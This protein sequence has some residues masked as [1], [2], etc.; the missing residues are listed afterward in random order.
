MGV[1][2]M[3]PLIISIM[4]LATI[5][6]AQEKRIEHSDLPAAVERTVS[7]Q[8]QGATIRVSPSATFVP[9]CSD[10]LSVQTT[11]P[12]APCTWRL[13]DRQSHIRRPAGSVHRQFG[14]ALRFA[15]V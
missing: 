15:K 10:A 1:S 11:R 14:T 2:R 6:V 4:L 13:S 8:S 9:F 3:F 7:A 5:S 12:C